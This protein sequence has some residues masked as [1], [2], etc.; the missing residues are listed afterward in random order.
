MIFLKLKFNI[1]QIFFKI[2]KKKNI[3]TKI[4]YKKI[5]KKKNKPFKNI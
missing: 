4:I 5:N 2:Q 3:L 1:I